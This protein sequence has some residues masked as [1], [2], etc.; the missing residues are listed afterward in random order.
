[1]YANW[2]PDA[3]GVARDVLGRLEALTAQTRLYHDTFYRTNLPYWLLDRI[4]SQV[5]ILSSMTCHWAKDG[6]FYALE[7]CNPD[8]GCCQGNATHVWGYP[9]AHA[10]LFPEIARRM[11]EKSSP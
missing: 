3:L 11:R 2:W 7:G 9:Q 10:R 1:M 8:S 5:A 4:T 6:F